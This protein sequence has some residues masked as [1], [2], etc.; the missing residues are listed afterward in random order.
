MKRRLHYE[1]TSYSFVFAPDCWVPEFLRSRGANY[2][3]DHN[4]DS[5]DESAAA[6]IGDTDDYNALLIGSFPSRDEKRAR[7]ACPNFF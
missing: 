7:H 4:N 6:D 1:K 3:D 2:S 5:R